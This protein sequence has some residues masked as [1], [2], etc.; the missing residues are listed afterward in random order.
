[1][2]PTVMI[3]CMEKVSALVAVVFPPCGTTCSSNSFKSYTPGCE[4]QATRSTSTL[5]PGPSP[6]TLRRMEPLQDTRLGRAAARARVK[7]KDTCGLPAS[8]RL[9]TRARTGMR[10]LPLASKSWTMATSWVSVSSRSVLSLVSLWGMMPRRWRPRDGSCGLGSMGQAIASPDVGM[11]MCRMLVNAGQGAPRLWA[12]RQITKSDNWKGLRAQSAAG[13]TR[14]VSTAF[15]LPS[16][17]SCWAPVAA[18]AL[19]RRTLL[20]LLGASASR[21]A[22]SRSCLASARRRFASAVRSSSVARPSASRAAGVVASLQASTTELVW[23]LRRTRR[24]KLT[25]SPGATATATSPGTVWTT[26]GSSVAG[27][28]LQVLLNQTTSCMKMPRASRSPSVRALER[29]RER[30]HSPGVERLAA[31]RVLTTSEGCTVI[32]K[33]RRKYRR[34]SSPSRLL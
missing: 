20:M 29:S 7:T 2:S 13:D 24:G 17:C 10:T 4:M 28:R 12:R 16:I 21:R 8:A 22:T 19:S 27:S 33:L 32:S 15:G 25:R 23:G 14:W 6:T 34:T 11:V 5:W 3:D 9:P 30:R 26:L 1:M 31:R 18:V